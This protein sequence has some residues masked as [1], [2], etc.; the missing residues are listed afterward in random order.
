MSKKILLVED[1]LSIGS[2]VEAVFI[3]NGSKVIWYKNGKEAIAAFKP[4]TFDI[5]I[6][7]LSLPDMDGFEISK[8]LRDAEPGIPFL[9]VTANMDSESKYKAFEQGCDDY[10]TKP[11]Q[12]RELVLRVEAIL[13][14]TLQN[15][16]GAPGVVGDDFHFDY[17]ARII[18]FQGK[19]V[20][21]SAKEAHIFYMVYS[22]FNQLVE[23]NHI[24]QEVWNS[25]DTYTSKCLDVYLSKIRKIIKNYTPLEILNEHGIGY[26]LI[27]APT[28]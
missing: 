3:G 10:I 4:N 17:N 2:L 5:C 18:S 16:L 9:F 20:K 11:F 26:K 22:N 15:Q 12:I 28:A 14:R 1:D 7:D 8:S 6:L 24:M 13:R 27:K 23:R 21:L 25:T 19:S